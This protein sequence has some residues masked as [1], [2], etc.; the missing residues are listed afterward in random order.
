LNNFNI[1]WLQNAIMSR[2]RK[3]DAAAAPA[4]PNKQR[5]RKIVA[6]LHFPTLGQVLGSL[7]E[8]V[9]VKLDIGR[10][11]GAT[12]GSSST[13][14]V[15]FPQMRVGNHPFR[16]TVCES[17]GSLVVTQ[18]SNSKSKKATGDKGKRTK[19]LQSS[20]DTMDGPLKPDNNNSDSNACSHSENNADCEGEELML[21]VS[22]QIVGGESNSDVRLA[23]VAPIV[24]SL[25]V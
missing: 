8:G 13:E 10:T 3:R 14:V 6:V 16:A 20:A 18:S 7:T 5:R 17:V 25:E 23:T 12:S 2:V 9:E 1:A 19:D 22:K 4:A 21:L 24:A 15:T 11:R